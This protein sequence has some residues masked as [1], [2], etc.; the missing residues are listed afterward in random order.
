MQNDVPGLCDANPANRQCQ[1]RASAQR[2]THVM[3]WIAASCS[4]LGTPS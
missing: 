3:S 1:D 4:L 2:S